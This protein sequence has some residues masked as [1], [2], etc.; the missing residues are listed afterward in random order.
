M[1]KAFNSLNYNILLHKLDYFCVCGLVL[2][3]FKSYLTL[4]YHFTVSNDNCSLCSLKKPGILQGNI[5][6]PFLHIIYI[7]DIFNV[8]LN[9]RC[10]FYPDDEVLIL[11]DRYVNN[12]I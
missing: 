12:L 3:W 2:N 5:L 7:N 6:G 4:H 10:V 11:C 1:S 9:V 8:K